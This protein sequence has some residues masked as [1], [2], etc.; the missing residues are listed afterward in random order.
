M[1]TKL[2]RPP[3]RERKSK[4]CGYRNCNKMIVNLDKRS[5]A[6]YRATKYCSRGCYGAESRLLATEGYEPPTC[7]YCG[8]EIPRGNRP[9]TVWQGLK[10]CNQS[11]GALY[12]FNGPQ[13]TKPEDKPV[14]PIRKKAK[15]DEDPIKALAES[16]RRK[17]KGK[18]PDVYF[19][20]F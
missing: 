17:H 14:K 1:P 18:L 3:S 16:Y 15:K 10:F 12:Q 19:Y 2:G 11:H 5:D 4:P 9:V 6:A 8:S 7:L 13:G 20:D